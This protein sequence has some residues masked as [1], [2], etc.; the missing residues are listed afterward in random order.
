MPLVWTSDCPKLTKDTKDAYIDYI[1]RRVQAYLSDIETDPELYDLLK[2]YETHN[3]SKPCKKYKNAAC[4][5]NFGQFFTDKT[6][7][8]E[9]LAED[10]CEENKCDILKKMTGNFN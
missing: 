5:F 4:R 2:T 6:I 1:D 3:H 8:A 10:L 9:P 7:V